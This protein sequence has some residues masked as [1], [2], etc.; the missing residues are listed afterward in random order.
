[1]GKLDQQLAEDRALRDAASAVFQEDL[2][3]L[4]S[5]LSPNALANRLGHRVEE[6]SGEVTEKFS[7]LFHE[8]KALV[9]GGFAAAAGSLAALVLIPNPIR[10]AAHRC[11]KAR[12]RQEPEVS[13]LRS[14]ED[15]AQNAKG[16]N[17][18]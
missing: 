1:M 11:W 4:R 5:S 16:R 12:K 14:G 9:L 18:E 7:E 8:N 3:L 2:A 15:L 13:K 17:H 6:S 10:S